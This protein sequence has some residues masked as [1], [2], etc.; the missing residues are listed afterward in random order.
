MLD[1]KM[2]QQD[3][4]DSSK[5]M[6]RIAWADYAKGICIVLVVML[7]AVEHVEGVAGH[8]GWLDAIVAFARP[9][10]MPDFFFVSGVLLTLAIR[11]DWRTFLDRKVIHF[12]YFYALWLTILIVFGSKWIAAKTGWSGVGALY[13]KSFVH[14]YSMLWFIYLL[15]IF[16]VLT[17]ALHRVPPLLVWLC[18]A[19]LQV[20][21]LETG[22]KVIDKFTPYYVFFYSG[23]LLAPYV[24]RF[25]DAVSAGPARAV[26]CLALWGV[27]NGYL[28]F[29]DYALLPGISLA[30]GL[31]GAAVV[32]AV[33]ALIT[34]TRVFEPLGYCGRNSL[35]V[36]LA[37]AIPLAVAAK[38]LFS[39]GLIK[40]VGSI[41]ALIT[42][43]AIAGAL[44][45]NRLVRGTA[46]RFLFERPERFR[47]ERRV[48]RI[49]GTATA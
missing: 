33:S 31:I 1:F 36:Y 8:A 46:L 14:P 10:R 13:L 17:K 32:V 44:L 38:L 7:Y 39:S 4:R 2:T 23:Y 24:L 11:R 43:A 37:F 3:N 49:A 16:F 29:T 22:I 35:V 47:L 34:K 18:A 42:L 5:R 15:P 40:D 45:L 25:A 20:A 9:F 30:L 12:A 28:V 6:T 48:T 26:V 41:A 19:A 27:L 21:G